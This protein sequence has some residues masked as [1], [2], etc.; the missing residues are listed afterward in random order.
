MVHYRTAFLILNARQTQAV[1]TDVLISCFLKYDKG[2][3]KL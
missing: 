2:L 1:S 3:A